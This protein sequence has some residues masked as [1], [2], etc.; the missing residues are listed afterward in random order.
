V[1]L[2]FAAKAAT[3]HAANLPRLQVLEPG[4][5]VRPGAGLCRTSRTHAR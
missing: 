4:P 1:R 3:S 5:G 2:A